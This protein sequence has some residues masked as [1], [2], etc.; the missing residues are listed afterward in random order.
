MSCLHRD[1]DPHICKKTLQDSGKHPLEDGAHLSGVQGACPRHQ[2]AH[3]TPQPIKAELMDHA[4][5][6]LWGSIYT[7]HEGRFDLRALVHLRRLYK[8]GHT[9][10][11]KP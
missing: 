4:P 10:G 6:R 2:G 9:P 5:N 3:P 7:V 8:Q 11:L 1:K